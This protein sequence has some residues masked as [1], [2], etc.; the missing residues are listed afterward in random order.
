MRLGLNIVKIATGGFSRAAGVRKGSGL[1]LGPEPNCC[2]G[3]YNT[4]TRTI[5]IGPVLPPKIRHFK[6]TPLAEFKY[7]SC[8]RIVT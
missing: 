7:L 2:N 3:F 4:K 1:T 5:A 6:L 8:D